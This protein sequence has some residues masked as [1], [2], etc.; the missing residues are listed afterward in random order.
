MSPYQLDDET[1]IARFRRNNSEEDNP[2]L[3]AEL[4]RRFQEDVAKECYRYLKDRDEA[5][6]VS[7]EVWIRVITKLP[8]YD[9]TKPFRPWL[10]TIVKNRCFDHLQQNKDLLHQELSLKIIDSLQEEMETE[11][12][13][14]PTIELLEELMEKISGQGKLVLLLKHYRGWSN[15][16]IQKSLEL[17]EG[18]V[19]MRLSRSREKIRQLYAVYQKEQSQ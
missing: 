16:E 1:I 9:H 17:S 4:V 13:M 10:F 18:T 14:T 12:G 11:V 15:K 5:Q 6:D 2:K 19:K 8:Q 3:L 7:Q